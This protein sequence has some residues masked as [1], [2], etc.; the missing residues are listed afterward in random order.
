MTLKSD[1]TAWCRTIFRTAWTT[2]EGKDVPTDDSKIGLKNDGINIKAAVLYADL[3]D[4]TKLVDAETSEFAAEVYKTFL[5][6]AAQVIRDG[7]GTITAYDGDRVMA[8]F[9][10]STP[11]NDAVRTAMKIRWAVEKIIT[12]QLRDMYDHKASFEVP[13]VIGIDTSELL[14]AKTGVRGANDLVWIGRAANYAAKLSALPPSYI[15]ITKAVYDL[16]NK[17]NKFSE[18]VN[19]WEERTWLFNKSSI[20]R[21][22]YRRSFD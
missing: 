14:V 15:Y 5:Y 20:Y 1:L 21:S 13:H 18:D 8:V 4:S 2:R 10:G 16:L 7:G 17:G 9:M 22:S 11:N 12:P 3:A 19:M 6:C